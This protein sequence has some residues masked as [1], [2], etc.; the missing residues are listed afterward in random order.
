M[1]TTCGACGG[2]L[3]E[4]EARCPHCGTTTGAWQPPRP[5]SLRENQ[6]KDDGTYK[7]GR[8]Y[9]WKYAIWG[10]V[11]IAVYVGFRASR[12]LP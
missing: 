6:A 5:M 2:H 10:A 7:D 1:A 11:V 8:G 12:L 4:G 9:D 3:F